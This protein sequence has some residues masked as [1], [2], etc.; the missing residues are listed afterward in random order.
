M[1]INTLEATLFTK[2]RMRA[3]LHNPNKMDP[4]FS[5]GYNI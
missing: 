1:K 2:E 4:P 3:S 5:S